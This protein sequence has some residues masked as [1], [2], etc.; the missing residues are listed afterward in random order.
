MRKRSI[1]SDYNQLGR[2]MLSFVFAIFL[3]IFL[4]IPAYAEWQKDYENAMDL[5]KKN[6]WD[7]AIPKLQAAIR[8]KNDEGSNI[9]FY[10]M[11]FGDYFPHF[12]LGWAYFNQKNYAQAMN[13]FQ[14]SEKFGAIQ[15]KGDL[16]QKM[17]DMKSLSRAQIASLNSPV[18]PS[19][20][21]PPVQVTKNEPPPEEKKQEEKKPEE[22]KQEPVVTPP[23]QETKVPEATRVVP[24]NKEETKVAKQE[25]K[26]PET[27]VPEQ[28]P[29]VVT[30]TPTV[31]VNAENEK[32]VV[33]NGARKYFE[34][35]FDGAIYLLTTAVEAN[36]GNASAQFLLGCA[37]ASK[38][39]LSGSQDKTFLQN[40]TAAF[41]KT[42]Q[43]SPGYHVKNR[44]VFSPA[45]LALF[46]KT[47]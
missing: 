47:S 37:Y 41:Q 23:P 10:G 11:K 2:T 6:Q 25:E 20:I 44:T 28:K 46:E 7:A 36:S 32:F 33:K 24:E 8:D 27:K 15:R 30:P 16:A 3:S 40:A 1:H 17:E 21:E 5:I 34:G 42:K 9:K 14:Q 19:T 39:L 13:E 22:K 18:T 12:Y 4:A 31:D 43:I 38:Y 45:V 29:P 35:D 26:T